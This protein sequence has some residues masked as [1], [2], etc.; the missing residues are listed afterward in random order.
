M[1]SQ[2]DPAVQGMLL[3]YLI[4]SSRREYVQHRYQPA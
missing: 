1:S 3:L 4:W 2:V